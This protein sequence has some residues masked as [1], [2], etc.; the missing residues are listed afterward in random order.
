MIDAAVLGTTAWTRSVK[1]KPWRILL[2]ALLGASYVMFMFVPSMSFLFTF[3]I[4]LIMSILMIYITFGF[5]SL[6]AFLRNFGAFY[7]INFAAAG[8]ILGVH[9]LWQSS[10]EL[11]EGM[12]FSR[13][14]GVTF[15]F[16]VGLIFTIV[17]FLIA[18]LLY[19]VVYASKKQREEMT[20]YLA[21][22]SVWIDNEI[23]S[24]IGLI[25]TGN[26]LYDP[27]TRTPVMIMEV[28]AWK[29]H[30]PETWIKRIQ[31]SETEELLTSLGAEE[32][33][34]QDRIRLVPYRG[35][36]RGTQFMIALKPDKVIITYNQ[37]TI[38]ASKVLI[39]LD[40][41]KLSADGSYHAIIHP[42][43]MNPVG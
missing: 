36:N 33:H 12:L 16:Q 39:G 22:V 15:Q 1:V 11:W 20:T 5:G 13:S 17:F 34:W 9:Y 40:G 41:G 7:C 6:Q 3:L 38:E 31:R 30:L 25:D 27:L 42:K 14:G 24:C 2:A 29:E 28:E 26:H 32:F 4:K 21:E 10:S 8:G 37:T 19:R 35:V 18:I 43:L 23:S